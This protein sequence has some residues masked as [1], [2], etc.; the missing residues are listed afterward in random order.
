[1]STLKDRTG[2]VKATKQG[3]IIKIIKYT[4]CNNIEV[5]FTH[6]GTTLNHKSYKQF[7][8]GTIK[9]PNQDLV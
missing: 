2:E 9:Y 4:N 6:D 8:E 7:T 3:Y 1:M 5:Q